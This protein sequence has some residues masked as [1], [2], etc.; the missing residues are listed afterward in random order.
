MNEL[1]ILLFVCS[2]GLFILTYVLR[3]DTAIS[4]MALFVAVCSIGQTIMDKSLGDLEVVLLVVPTFYIMLMSGL[5]AMYRKP[6]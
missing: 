2:L 5:S 6:M 3:R 4:W 1:T